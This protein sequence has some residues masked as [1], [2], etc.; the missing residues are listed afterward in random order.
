MLNSKGFTR[1]AKKVK[2]Q[3]PLK[4]EKKRAS[5]PNP[6]KQAHQPTG[7]DVAP[8]PQTPK[9]KEKSI[10]GNATPKAKR[11]GKARNEE[12]ALPTSF[13]LVAGS[14]EK[15]LYGLDGS[16]TLNDESKL[17]FHLKPIFIF[18]AH[19]SCI[20]AVAASPQGGKWLATGSADEIIKVWDL[21]R[22]KEIG[23]LM[24][25]E[26]RFFLELLLLV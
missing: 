20:K 3:T 9:G 26:G 15:L 8:I 4:G 19:V 13:K 7:K 24:H 16:V 14:Y 6:E 11:E 22:R 2:L 1:H 5:S 23:G 25:H 21:R 10:E 17:E 12:H 18:P